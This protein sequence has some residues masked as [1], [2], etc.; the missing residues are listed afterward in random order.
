M[1]PYQG[2]KKTRGLLDYS[3]YQQTDNF[4]LFCLFSPLFLDVSFNLLRRV[5]LKF[6]SFWDHPRIGEPEEWQA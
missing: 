2:K 3:S 1:M 6:F 4:F 5:K